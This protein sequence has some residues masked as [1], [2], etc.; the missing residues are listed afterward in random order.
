MEKKLKTALAAAFAAP[1]PER[2]AAFFRAHRRRE[3]GTA[4]LMMTQARYVRPRTWVG[5]VLLLAG[6]LL[7]AGGCG[8][9]EVWYA[10]ALTPLLALTALAEWGRSRRYGMEELERSC[11]TPLRTA[12]L[13]RLAAVGAVHLVLLTAAAPA[14]AAWG[15]AGLTRAGVYLL[16]PYLLTAAAGMELTRRIPG[17]E[18]LTACAAAAAAVCALGMWAQ[19]SG[20]ELYGP[21]AVPLW[22]AALAA[23][24]TAWVFELFRNF[25]EEA[26]L[27]S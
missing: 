18:G 13:A 16:T 17:R 4:E 11:R 21:G 26:V 20:P 23:A 6:M 9:G 24:L 2:R 15:G 25:K 22:L 10:S 19:S 5:S 8:S 27:W 7:L 12:R 3:L 14:L 1:E